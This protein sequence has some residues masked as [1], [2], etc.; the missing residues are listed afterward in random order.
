MQG[1][2]ADMASRLWRVLP[3]NWFSFTSPLLNAVLLGLGTAW[4]AIYA[5]IQAVR[6]QARIATA[7]GPFLDLA[8][9]DFFGAGLARWPNEGDNA[10]LVRIQQEMLR[11]RGTRAA[12]ALAL[13]EL[14]G[15][16]PL[17]FEPAL[18]TDTGGYAIGGV[19]YGAGGGYG[20]LSLPYQCFVTVFMPAGGTI[21]AL[22]GYGTGGYLAYGSAPVVPAAAD[23]FTALVATTPIGTIAWTRIMN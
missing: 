22:A 23:I 10:Y 1:D 11:P 12:L 7:T 19:G 16:A 6:S 15:V 9:A 3:T 20:N 14:T 4:A 17:I 2:K 18:T 21:P 5:L 13:T 8:A